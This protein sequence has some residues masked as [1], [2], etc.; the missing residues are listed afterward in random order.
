MI[1]VIPEFLIFMPFKEFPIFKAL[2]F[3]VIPFIL[4]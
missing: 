1:F 2:K 4:G 3:V